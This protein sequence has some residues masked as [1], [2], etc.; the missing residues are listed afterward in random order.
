MGHF[1]LLSKSI[2]LPVNVCKIAGWVIRR[3]V[4]L[5]LIWVYTVY[6]GLSV[7]MLRVSTVI[8]LNQT[9]LRNPPG[10]GG[11]VI[12]SFELGDVLYTMDVNPF[13]YYRQS[14]TMRSSTFKIRN[15]ASRQINASRKHIILTPLNP[16]FILQNWGLQGYTIVFFFLL[17]NIDC[18]YSLEPPR[19]GSSNE[20]T[21]SLCWA[22][23]W[24]KYQI[25]CY[26]K[27]FSF[28]RWNFL[29]I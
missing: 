4:L 29:Y 1:S 26:L 23:I 24:K 10:F 6:S 11:C 5:H 20:Y 3:R 12:L 17:K 9:P 16:T 8:W 14:V 15:H 13:Y 19:R 25:F 2:L 21:Q 22:E 7:R 18:G 28:W 27:I